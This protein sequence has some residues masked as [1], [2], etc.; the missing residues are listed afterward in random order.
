MERKPI[1][2]LTAKQAD[3]AKFA[4][5]LFGAGYRLDPNAPKRDDSITVI[6]Y[7]ICQTYGY[8]SLYAGDLQADIRALDVDR[9]IQCATGYER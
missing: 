8:Y 2:A 1:V 5:V 6:V 9:A 4:A 7:P 3:L